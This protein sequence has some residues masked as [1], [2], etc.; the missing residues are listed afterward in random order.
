MSFDK[1]QKKKIKNGQINDKLAYKIKVGLKYQEL[2]N[3]LIKETLI[4][5]Y[6][7]GEQAKSEFAEF[8]CAYAFFRVPLFRDHILSVIKRENDP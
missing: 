3:Y 2:L 4:T 6:M 5:L 7:K 8:F 1:S